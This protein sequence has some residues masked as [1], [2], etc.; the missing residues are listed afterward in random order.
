[1]TGV[2]SG[3]FNLKQNWQ[4]ISDT[5]TSLIGAPSA[6]VEQIGRIAGGEYDEQYEAFFIDCNAQPSLDLEIGQ[7]TYHIEGKN[8]VVPAGD[9][10][11]MLSLFGMNSY[12]FGPAWILGDPF[13]RQ[14]CQ[15]HD[16]VK[17]QIGFAPSLQ[18]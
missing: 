10:R 17:K 6:V 5:G 12:G 18:K 11:C 2:K 9:G 13:I 8:L 15:I 1:M 4:V 7:N 3:S 14:F 16:V